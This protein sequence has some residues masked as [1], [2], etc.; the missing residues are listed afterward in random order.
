M[1]KGKNALLLLLALAMVL[2]L[3]LAAS[4]LAGPMGRGCGPGGAMANL[5]PAQASQLFDLKEKMHAETVDLRKQMMVKRAEMGAL[6]K[7]ENPDQNVILAKQKELNALRE[8]MQQKMVA[9]R[10]EAKKLAP[11]A[12]FGMGH[13]FGKGMG[14]GGGCGPGGGPGMAPP[15]PPEK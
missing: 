2:S 11:D 13:G 9:F 8:Q 7:A 6:W 14:H 3:G 10:L 12:A 5:T 15:P 1:K 4:A